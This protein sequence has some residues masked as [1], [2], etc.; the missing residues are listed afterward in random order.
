MAQKWLVYTFAMLLSF[1]M[2]RFVCIN[3]L[4]EKLDNIESAFSNI[5]GSVNTNVLGVVDVS[6]SVNSDVSGRI[7]T[8]VS[9]TITAESPIFGFQ[10]RS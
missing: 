9:G 3:P 7:S 4:I 2:F 5:N 10:V 6:G 1:L 8:E